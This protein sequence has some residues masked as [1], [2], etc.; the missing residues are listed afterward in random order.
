M[1]WAPSDLVS[2]ADLTAYESTVLTTFGVS[3]FAEK[4]RRALEDWLGPILASQGLDLRRLRTRYEPSAVLGFTGSAYSDQTAAAT[5]EA[6]DDINLATIFATPSTDALYVGFTSPFRG[7]SLRLLESVSA[8][9][10]LLSVAYWADGWTPLT[11]FDGTAKTTGKTFSG[12]GAITWSVPLDWSERPINTVGPYYWV[13]VTVSAVPTSAKA[14]QIGVIQRSALCAPA[15]LRT[16][17]LI[18]REAPTGG[19]G[20]WADKAE[21][22]E[23]E[24]DAALQRALPHVGG[25]FDTDE[26]D[27]IS[28]TEAAQTESEVSD[29]PFRLERA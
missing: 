19:P 2:D 25:E 8:V 9:A 11:V 7:L 3:D 20:P 26:S 27:Q 16:L 10:S 12:G 14:S 15:A 13:K 6:S 23:T 24:A 18:M 28:A 21:W 4:R 29:L 17:T 22:Y 1:N 5:S